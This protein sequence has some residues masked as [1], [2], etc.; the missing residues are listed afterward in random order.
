MPTTNELLKTAR[1]AYVRYQMAIKTHGPLD[2]T[3]YWS[4]QYTNAYQE[5]KHHTR[6]SLTK[7]HAEITEGL[8]K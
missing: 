3:L 5:L 6:W 8:N 7:L 1:D 4:K 2:L